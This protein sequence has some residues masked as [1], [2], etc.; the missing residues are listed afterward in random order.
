VDKLASI[1]TKRI[2][3]PYAKHAIA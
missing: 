1:F 3:Q 2:W